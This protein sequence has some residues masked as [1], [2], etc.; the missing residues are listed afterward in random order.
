[1]TK[2]VSVA[3]IV[4]IA[5]VG[6]PRMVVSVVYRRVDHAGTLAAPRV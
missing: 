1:M 2:P 4:A 6:Q 5:I 3:T